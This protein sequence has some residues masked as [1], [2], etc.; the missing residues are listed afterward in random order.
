MTTTVTTA[1]PGVL[2]DRV[3]KSLVAD[4]AMIL[5]VTA[6][7]ALLAQ[8]RIVVGRSP[9]PLTGQTLV[10]LLGAAALGPWR[11]VAAQGLYVAVGLFGL[12]V[13]T[14]WESGLAHASGVTGGYLA[15]FVIAS[16]VVGV[17][18]TR[19][20][21]RRPV[22]TALAFVAGSVTIYLV[23]VPWFMIVTGEAFGA[24]LWQ[25]AGVFLVGDALKALIAAG[26]L[27]GAWWLASR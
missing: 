9:V 15:G 26:L 24:A 2:A 17:L 22:S 6:L 20:A 18:A 16:A 8:V 12:P 1:P 4:A 7:T 14:G 19:G 23:A 10:V 13:F 3:P 27:P 25:G 11:A 21:D 5:A